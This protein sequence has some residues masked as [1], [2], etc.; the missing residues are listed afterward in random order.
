MAINQNTTL[1][2]IAYKSGLA[3]S[4]VD[5]G[6]YTITNAQCAAPSFSPAAGTYGSAQSVTIS[7]TTSGA[8]I[9]YTTDGTTPSETNGTVYSSAVNISANTTLQ[10]IAYESGMTDSPI[11]S[12]NYYIQCAAPTFNPVAGTYSSAQSVS[13]SST[14]SGATIRYTT[15][16]TT[17]SETNGTVYSSAVNISVNTTLQAIAYKTGMADSP[18]TS[19]IFDIQCAAPTFSPVA[20]TYGS[21]QS[22][23]ISSTTS[24]A[25]IRYTTDGSTP[26][27]TNGTI[28]SSAVNISVNTTLQAIA[29][30]TGMADSPITSG[31]YDIQCAAPTFSPSAGTFTSSTVVTI[32]STTS[33]A[34]I[35]YTTD[36]S[37]PSESA[38]TVYSSA[39]NITV[40]ST[41]KAIA[42]KTGMA[43][44]P[45]TS[46]VYTIQVAAPTFSPLAGTYIGN[47]A[48]TITSAT[49]GATIR[50]TTN[51][52]TPTET[53]GTVYSSAVS[54]TAACTLQAIAYKTG[55]TD[56]SVTS[57][58][59]TVWTTSDIGTVGVAGSASYAS[60]TYTVAG[61]GAGIT[62]TAD[63]FRYVYQQISG[64]C[65][66]IARVATFSS[67][68]SA[69]RAGVMMRQNLNANSIEASSLFAPSNTKVY[70]HRRTSAGGS[71]STSNGAAAAAPYW[72]K[73]VRSSNTLSAYKSTNGTTWT[74]VG[75]NTTVTMS[76][77]IYIGL[78]VTSGSTS[79]AATA[80]FDNVS[81]TSP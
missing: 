30:K 23:S 68:T 17:P 51:G 56:S 60:P 72:V 25:T 19:G 11:T 48:V 50:Y 70:F 24:G 4:I 52:T 75:S 47:Q 69:A 16:G 53:V 62:G 61:A 63:A 5:G 31:I 28:Y 59:Y 58:A 76:D 78:A 18:I 41:L 22:V 65:T 1:Q 21:A 7:T 66:I 81:I 8:T 40:S 12:G 44:S 45:I 20:G 29:Y 39:V 15:D 6:I 2:A 35:R 32:S 80:T 54:L 36:G 64:N 3:N 13:I 73:L 79:A 55:C 49:S 77:P 10:A 67:S 42:Y 46:G 26:S 14:T 9:R 37:T 38:G 33:G 71:T 27:E 43:D 74:Q 57:G 34:T